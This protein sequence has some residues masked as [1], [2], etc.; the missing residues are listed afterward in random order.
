MSTLICPH[1]TIT[2]KCHE[3]SFSWESSCWVPLYMGCKY[4]HSL[5]IFSFLAPLISFTPELLCENL[6]WLIQTLS[7]GTRVKECVTT[8]Q[9]MTCRMWDEN[10]LVVEGEWTIT[11]LS[12]DLINK[13]QVL[14]GN[15]L[16]IPFLIL[17]SHLFP[18]AF[19][20][21]PFLPPTFHSSLLFI[22]TF[23]FF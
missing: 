3:L 6:E 9:S 15:L 22:F 16:I 10:A 18:L 1:I 20:F 11:P 12:N 13:N 2:Y 8:E 4:I 17:Q 5:F 21:P 7:Q 23:C 19:R 14:W